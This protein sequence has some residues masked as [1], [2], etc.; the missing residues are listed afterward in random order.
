[1]RKAGTCPRLHWLGA[2]APADWQRHR[3]CSGSPATR[4]AYGQTAEQGREKGNRE[5]GK[6][7]TDRLR[8]SLTHTRT[9]AHVCALC[10]GA[11]LFRGGPQT[12]HP[13]LLV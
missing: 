9:H 4:R 1:M 11:R 13:D 3:S 10:H 6:A 5:N 7:G 12:G 2:R 8:C